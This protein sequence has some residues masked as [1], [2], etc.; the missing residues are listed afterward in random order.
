MRWLG[1][2]IRLRALFAR[3]S[4]EEDLSEELNTHIELQARK[5]MAQGLNAQ[6]AR[7]RA[8]IEFGAMEQAREACRE[9]DGWR[10]ID[11]ALRNSRQAFRSLAKS[12]A[13]AFISVL[14]L[15]VGIGANVAV[16]ST[17]DALFLRPLP[18][19]DPG[20]L[21]QIFSTGKQDQ[22]GGLFS[23]ALEVLSHNRAF[24]GVCGVA[25]HYDA[26][27]IGSTLR[28][29]GT[30]AYSGGCFQTLG[31]PVQLGRPLT[32]D[33]DHIGAEGVAVITDSL[34]HSQFGGRPDVLGQSI[35]IGSGKFTIVG[36]TA[37]PFTGLLL[38]FPELVMIP[39]ME[40]PDFWPDGSRRTNYYVSVL[41]RRAPGISEAQ[42]LASVVTQRKAILEQSVPHHYSPAGRNRYLARSLGL[43]SASTGFDYFLRRRFGQ[44]LYAIFGLC[45]VMLLMACINLSS[46]LLA[47]GLRR[48]R[49][50]GVRLALGAGRA[51]IAVILVLEN[52]M[53]VLA[54]AALGIVVGLAGA[55]TIL[56]RGGQIFGNF[57]LHI[58]FDIRVIAFVLGTVIV[59]AGAF[60]AASVWQAHRLASVDVLKQSGRGVIAPNT[61]AQK[62][63]LAVQIAL[64]LALITGSVLFSASVRNMYHIDFGIKP[65]N[66][67]IALLSPRPGGYRNPIYWNRV[68]APYY[69]RLLNEI[70]ALPE[71]VSATFTDTVPF[72]GGAYQADIAPIEGGEV[73]RGV[74]ARIIG[75]ADNYF[76]TL[77]AKIVRGED[78]RRA[79]A[80][81][82]EPGVI[83]SES[84]ATHLGGGRR[85]L[86]QHIK[87]GTAP[88][89]QRLKVV[90][91]C[92]NMDTNLANLNDTKPFL[93]FL[94]F[95]QHQNLQG[96]PGLL[97]KT[98]GTALDTAAIRRIVERNGHEFVERFSSITAEINDGLVEN[99]LL[100]Y[101]SAA[102]AVLALLMAAV[103][104]FGLLS[105]QV[106]NRTAEIGIRMALGAKHAQIHRL[107]I[108][109]VARLL[110]IG[111]AAG[112]ALTFAVQKLIAS[113]LY[114]VTAFNPTILV[115]AIF[116]LV[117]TALVAAAIP[118]RR[119]TK[120]DPIEALRHE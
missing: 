54:G 86:G 94:D 43:S 44:P 90:G 31:L 116:V 6:E 9:V 58:G 28:N 22:A 98:R 45:A 117:S 101:F 13:F 39:L 93:A 40:Q 66:V 42:A 102:F 51:H 119:A 57:D 107:V 7:R 63:L 37:K 106:A 70:E 104:L 80:S 88:D 3:R 97:I 108:G 81:A 33:D 71:V 2:R 91:I 120:I 23:P 73:E 74:Q 53:L 5:H 110:F 115:S 68:A 61:S 19:S 10:W 49:E 83:L 25:T 64:T 67:W 77:G 92:S 4:F 103:G 15:T 12:P 21:V 27:E 79:N 56:A 75:A 1:F 30:A 111:I 38:G 78:F 69:R 55:R 105:Y 72:A 20:K 34:W 96:Y 82:D 95:W 29:L 114:G 60:V 17:V 100:A 62:I 35:R 59:V 36:V 50:V 118:T 84:L 18:V 48:Q 87:I 113:L 46:L 14:I 32:P 41:A 24:Q 26:V 85:L 47:R 65:R 99:R 11:A 8:R 112:I 16:F 89:L 109:Q 76:A 52:L